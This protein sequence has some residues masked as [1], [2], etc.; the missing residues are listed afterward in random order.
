MVK[1]GSADQEETQHSHQQHKAA[2]A[3]VPTGGG[4]QQHRQTTVEGSRGGIGRGGGD[5]GPEA[6]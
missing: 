4:I 5:T 3:A 2:V 1:L 6:A